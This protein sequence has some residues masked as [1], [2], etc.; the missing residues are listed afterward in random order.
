[1]PWLEIPTDEESI[2]IKKR[3]VTTVGIIGIPRLI[4]LEGK[5]GELISSSAREEV[6]KVIRGDEVT[7]VV[8]Q[9]DPVKLETSWLL[10][11]RPPPVAQSRKGASP[12]EATIG[13]TFPSSFNGSFQY[14]TLPSCF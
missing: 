8:V 11:G 4:V 7:R 14:R 9:D 10:N 13:I 1:M 2:E 12:W 3:L 5:T 6:V